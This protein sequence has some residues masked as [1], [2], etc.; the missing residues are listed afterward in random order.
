MHDILLYCSVIF[1]WIF[2][3]YFR[4]QLISY[5]KST[6]VNGAAMN[7]R[8]QVFVIIVYVCVSDMGKMHATALWG[9]QRTS[10][11]SLELLLPL[12]GFQELDSDFQAWVA[13]AFT[14]WTTPLET[15]SHVSYTGLNL[16]CS[17]GWSWTLIFLLPKCLLVIFLH[18]Y[19]HMHNLNFLTFKIILCVWVFY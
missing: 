19:T 11:W 4:I 16:L 6:Y 3:I 1:H 2:I 10:L 5:V 17:G 12:C 18:M 14:R 9:G 15:V 13:S 7:L 8:V